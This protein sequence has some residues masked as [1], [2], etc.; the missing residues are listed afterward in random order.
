MKN[1]THLRHHC[2]TNPHNSTKISTVCT[3]N[4]TTKK[5]KYENIGV[6]K[7]EGMENL[8]HDFHRM[9]DHCM[10]SLF[11]SENICI[12]HHSFP[13]V[14]TVRSHLEVALEKY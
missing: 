13:F 10:L 8:S 1:L 4:N 3:T 2:I 9:T 11:I 6:E 12:K 14:A 5:K 7:K